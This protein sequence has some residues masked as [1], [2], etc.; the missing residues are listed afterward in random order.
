[1]RIFTR[2]MASNAPPTR[3]ELEAHR[4]GS[5]L[6][7][8]TALAAL[9]LSLAA[10]VWGWSRL[11][12]VVGNARTAGHTANAADMARED[13]VGL[14]L[15]ALGLLGAFA[16]TLLAALSFLHAR[17]VERALAELPG[18]APDSAVR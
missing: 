2:G 17:H 18:G 7:L 11:M 3:A 6:R 13:P 10:L 12:V 14:A 1:M 4:D 15:F 16:R 5:R 9:A 8:R